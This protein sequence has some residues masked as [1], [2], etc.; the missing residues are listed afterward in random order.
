MKSNE[1]VKLEHSNSHLQ[2]K[3]VKS[4]GETPERTIN[5]KFQTNHRGRP[6]LYILSGSDFK[7]EC[8]W[9]MQTQH[10]LCLEEELQWFTRQ[11]KSQT[12]SNYPMLILYSGKRG[13]HVGKFT[14]IRAQNWSLLTRSLPPENGLERFKPEVIIFLSHQKC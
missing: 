12:F 6:S 13:S 5:N 1:L 3:K 8:I 10:G 9:W 7:A 4:N 11:M 2:S 14:S